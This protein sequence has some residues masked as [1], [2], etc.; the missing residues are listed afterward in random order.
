LPLI[1]WTSAFPGWENSMK[2]GD[3]HHHRCNVA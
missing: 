2:G 1:R 3:H